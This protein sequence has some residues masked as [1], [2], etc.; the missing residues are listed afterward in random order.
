MKFGRVPT[1]ETTTRGSATRKR[2]EQHRPA[3]RKVDRVTGDHCARAAALDHQARYRRARRDTAAAGLILEHERAG[4]VGAPPPLG[5]L[6]G[7][8]VEATLLRRG[9]E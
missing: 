9:V 7:G 2:L 6:S 1:T 3:R 8:P 5:R 4:D